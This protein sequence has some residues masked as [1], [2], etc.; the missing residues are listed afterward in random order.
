MRFTIFLIFLGSILSAQNHLNDFN[1]SGKVKNLESTTYLFSD[2]SKTNPSGFLDS[3]MYDAIQLDFDRKGNLIQRENYL[4]Y[5]GK[6]G[7]FD[8]TIYQF[9]FTN[10]IEKQETTL[11][12]NGEEPRKI[13]Q[14]K[15]FYYIQNQ[16][17]RIDEFNTGRT[18]DQFWVTNLVY[19]GGRLKKKEFWMDDEIFSVTEF[20]NRLTKISSEK[21]FHNDGKLGKT[22]QYNYDENANLILKSTKSGNEKTEESFEYG[23]N[24]LKN[25]S[26][27]N[28]ELIISKTNFDENGLPNEIQ[29]FNYKTQKFDLYQFKFKY[30]AQNNWINCVI[31]ENQSPKFVIK[32][33]ISYY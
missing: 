32:R 14:K 6:L 24:F 29:K 30:D 28:N 27:R 8:R 11:V 18:S 2:N 4:D 7:L 5:R 22:I 21:T 20:E 3:E 25:Q 10:Q 31:L 26:I 15:Q 23:K 17:I 1:L 13:S 12:Q 33:T 19:D 9:N 16:L